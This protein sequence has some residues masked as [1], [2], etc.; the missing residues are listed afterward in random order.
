MTLAKAGEFAEALS[1]L[2]PLHGDGVS[3][4]TSGPST[5]GVGEELQRLASLRDSGVLSEEEFSAQ[6][7]KL[8]GSLPRSA[9]TS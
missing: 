5:Q 2:L 3:P 6:K 8:L 9:G 1:Q 7:A 4:M